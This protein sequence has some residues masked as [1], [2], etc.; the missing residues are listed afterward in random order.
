[1]KIVGLFCAQI[2]ETNLSDYNKFKSLTRLTFRQSAIH[3]YIS[4]L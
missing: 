1:M 4:L 3:V 2:Y